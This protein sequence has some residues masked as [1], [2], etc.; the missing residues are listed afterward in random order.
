D[1]SRQRPGYLT[2]ER[3]LSSVRLSQSSRRIELYDASAASCRIELME[4]SVQSWQ[5][6]LVFSHPLITLSARANTSG[7]IVRS[8]CFAAFSLIT[9]SN[10]VACC[11]GRS[12]GFV[13]LRILS[14]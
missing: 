5:R 7:G 8:I 9:N 1:K 11:T 10:F 2:D 12:A 3:G 4:K 13:P 14:T 6:S